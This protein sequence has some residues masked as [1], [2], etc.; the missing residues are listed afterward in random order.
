[1]CYSAQIERNYRK[2]VRL[3][4][5]DALSKKDFIKKYWQR[6]DDPKIKIP[7]A[8]DAWFAKPKTDEDFKITEAINAYNIARLSKCEQTLFAQ[9][10]RVAD[11]ERKLQTKSTKKALNDVRIG[12]DNVQDNLRWIADIKRTELLDR[13]ARI[14]PGYLAP[15]IVSEDGKPTIK[16][17]RY[18]CRPAGKPKFLDK[19]LETFNA[20]RDNLGGEFWKPLFGAHHGIMIINSFFEN[21]SRHKVEG[22]ELR[23]GEEDKGVEIEFHPLPTQEMYVACLWSHWQ[24][25]GEELDSFTAITDE[26]PPEVAAAGHDRCLIPIKEEH[27]ELWLNPKGTNLGTMQAILEDRARPYYEHRMAA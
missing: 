22:R 19:K 25:G 4:G 2:Y 14:F 13:D 6:I 20:R 5:L 10:K 17:M 12:N 21:V 18:G 7:K 1:M 9:R 11:A 27:I 23:A 15:V 8:I 24:E 3:W 16:L 26:P